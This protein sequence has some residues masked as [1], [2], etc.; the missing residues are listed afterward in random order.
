MQTV[1]DLSFFQIALLI[2]VAAVIVLIIVVSRIANI[3]I[4]I[5]FWWFALIAATVLSAIDGYYTVASI[6]LLLLVVFGYALYR[7]TRVLSRL[8][9]RS[10][11]FNS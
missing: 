2:D 8:Q 9:M 6:H 11:A 3:M 10:S 1:F 7:F 5:V 4:V